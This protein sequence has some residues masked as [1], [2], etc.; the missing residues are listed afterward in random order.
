M[1]EIIVEKPYQFQPPFHRNVYPWLFQR[2][3]LTD[4]FLHRFEGIESYELRGIDH[5]KESLRLR[6]GVILAP[7]H[8]RYSDPLVMGWVVR[9]LGVYAYAMASWHLFNQSWWQ[10]TAIRMAGGFSINREGIDRQAL[11][12]AID[13]IVD[14]QRPLI[15]F[16]EGSVFRSNDILQPLLDGV[17]FLARAA[18]RRR[19][20]IGKPPTFVH[21]I[22]IKYLFKGNVVTSITPI[23]EE[24]E[25]R[26]SWFK[27]ICQQFNMVDRVKR[28]REAFLATKEL[29]HTGQVGIGTLE[30]RRSRLVEHLIGQAEI[31]QFGKPSC[32]ESIIARI[33]NLRQRLV[34]ELLS[35][36]DVD[37]KRL[38][39]CELNRM[40]VAQQIMS[41][42]DS[43]LDQP[44]TNTRLLE[45]V[46]QLE[47]DIWDKAR[48]HRPLHAIIEIGE[49][50]EVTDSRPTKGE[51]DP[52]LREL[53]LSLRTKLS[54][55]A[56]EAE[57]IDS[58]S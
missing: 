36:S 13:A 40:Y 48:V 2:L 6:A 19:S 52:L 43:Y 45:T 22:A 42:P 11:D 37:R 15:I 44:V 57:V 30:E 56:Q 3:K 9:P 38:I 17:A 46:E 27:P 34:P 58:I 49:P 24:I 32:D 54:R 25:H 8:C 28:L 39:R 31:H 1:Q 21:P 50:I 29:E 35:G 55:L 23:V 4:R 12:T 5:L 41:Y 53:D 51:S 20:K 14:G 26:L 47:E 18:A 16:P 7:N 33:K 10:G